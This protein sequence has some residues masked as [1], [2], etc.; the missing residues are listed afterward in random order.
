MQSNIVENTENMMKM[1][2]NVTMSSQI[3]NQPIKTISK[4]S[5]TFQTTVP[6]QMQNMQQQ[7]MQMLS[8]QHNTIQRQ[9]SQ[10]LGYNNDFSS[11][12]N[13]FVN[14]R[15]EWSGISIIHV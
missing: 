9:N 1:T 11:Y 8:G 10:P 6:M 3:E 14:N 12:S 5:G 7:P 15:Y 2:K 13:N 4:S